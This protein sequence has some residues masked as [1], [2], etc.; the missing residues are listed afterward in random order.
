MSY[1]SDEVK[2]NLIHRLNRIEGQVR[3]INR[4]VEEDQYC[5]DILNQIS[6]VRSA[7]NRVGQILLESHIRG[8][9]A[10]A[11]EQKAGRRS[12]R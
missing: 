2:K 3:G 10:G 8:C 4:M 1:R 6:A 5:L 7:L 9:V 12:H 11:I